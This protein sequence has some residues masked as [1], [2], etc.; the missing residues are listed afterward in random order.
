V[1]RSAPTPGLDAPSGVVGGS[2]R[3]PAEVARASRSSFLTAF[4]MLPRA[5]RDALEA[6]Y[7]FC[8]VVDD[9]GDDAP[10]PAAAR[11]GLAFWS[12]EL[13]AIER[14]IPATPI[15]AAVASAIAGFG[16]D[17]G[18]LR[19][20]IAG[21]AMDVEG[22]RYATLTELDEYCRRVASA[23]GLACLPVFGARSPASRAYAELL[24]LALQFTNILR[25]LRDDARA[26][27]VYL[28]GDRLAAHGVDPQWLRGD[29]APER[30]ARGSPLDGLVAEFVGI[31]RERFVRA[32]AILPR[33]EAVA[34]APARVMG[35]VYRALLERIGR[36][37]AGLCRAE[38]V[39][40][41]RAIKLA[42]LA[43]AVLRA[44]LL[45]R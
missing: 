12:R 45:G 18:D 34:L 32:A 22:T 2:N 5:R 4:A 37:G 11:A 30:Y 44:K 10:S 36:R 41:P 9:A 8:R 13:D 3:S 33:A 7:A 19:L 17:P 21:V 23:V 28:P 1:I 25:D 20:V 26:G 15:G 43:R 31:A 6:V 39:R 16:V 14:G 29:A 27:R 38:R 42:I 35:E 24:G 40:V